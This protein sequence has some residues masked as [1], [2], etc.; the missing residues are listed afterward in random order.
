MIYENIMID[1]ETLGPFCDS[2]IL[3]IAIVPFNLMEVVSLH[4]LVS[5]GLY[6][7]LNVQE[8]IDSGRFVCRETL[9][10]W[11]NQSDSAKEILH[12]SK[13]DI[14]LET[15]LDKMDEY[16]AGIQFNKKTGFV[17]CRGIQFDFPLIQ[18]A[19]RQYG[20]TNE[21]PFSSWNLQDTK[22]FIRTLTC[23]KYARYELD[24][25]SA[26]DGFVAHNAL[27]DAAAEVMKVNELL[28]K[29]FTN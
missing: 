28:A 14:I 27:Y 17:H 5:R 22:T 29:H 11:K 25:K 23:D 8:Q 4:E 9:R 18:H 1:T 6:L 24:D 13:E 16:L 2:V 15:A 7:K 19:Y 10:W 12:P 26:L 21:M 20:R 3:S